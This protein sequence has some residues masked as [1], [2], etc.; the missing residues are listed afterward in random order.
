MERVW[1]TNGSTSVAPVVNPLNAACHA[2]YVPTDVYILDNPAITDV[3][4]SVTSLMKTVVT[5]HDG[6]E[7]SITVETIEDERDFDAII[8]Y[9]RGAIEAGND[10]AAD[11]A[12]DVTPGRK[13]WSIISF[14]AGFKYDVDHLYY[15]HVDGAYFGE[16][17]P[18]IPRPG[19]EL[20]DFT[21][22]V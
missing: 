20:I 11:I 9:L 21:E 6:A 3:T 5:A 15:T 8:A 10:A 16:S 18:T 22:V 2:G 19:I 17:F 1:V 14:R 12:V 7:P 4:D 13:F